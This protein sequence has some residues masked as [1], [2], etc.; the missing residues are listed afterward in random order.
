GLPLDI[1]AHCTSGVFV[2]AQ[3]GHPDEGQ[4]AAAVFSSNTVCPLFRPGRGRSFVLNAIA[5]HVPNCSTGCEGA[6][7]STHRAMDASVPAE[8]ATARQDQAWQSR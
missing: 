4:S 2:L 5:G 1:C 3:D 7:L 8:K 6:I